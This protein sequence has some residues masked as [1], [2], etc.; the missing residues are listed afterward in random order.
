M[1]QSLA[2]YEL[3]SSY[4]D[5]IVG[6]DVLY[7]ASEA[8]PFG[9]ALVWHV[10]PGEYFYTREAIPQVLVTVD[11]FPALCTS[12]ACDY[13]YYESAAVITDFDLTSNTLTITGQHLGTPL[14]VTMGRMECTDVSASL[15]SITCTLNGSL[16]A[17]SWKPIVIEAEGQVRYDSSVDALTVGMIITDVD[18]RVDINPAGGQILTITGEHFPPSLNPLYELEVSLGGYARCVPISSTET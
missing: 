12:L 1:D 11:E 15:T 7:Q 9:E 18:P 6:R 10:I 4:D 8:R 3:V 13:T 2:Q 16:P 17:G 14:E 5:P